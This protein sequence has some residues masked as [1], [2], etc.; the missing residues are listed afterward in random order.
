MIFNLDATNLAS[1]SGSSKFCPLGSLPAFCWFAH[2]CLIR[3]TRA[4]F[5]STNVIKGYSPPVY[6]V[7]IPSNCLIQG[8]IALDDPQKLISVIMHHQLIDL[9]TIT[10]EIFLPKV[11]TSWS[12]SLAIPIDWMDNYRPLTN[13]HPE[14]IVCPPYPLMADEW[15]CVRTEISSMIGCFWLSNQKIENPVKFEWRFTA[16]A[17]P[18]VNFIFRR[19]ST[20]PSF[21]QIFWLLREA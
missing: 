3:W 9:L 7:D 6:G 5:Q 17:G 18:L 13:P 10:I 11:I 1:C 16:P 20:H 8:N 19:I 14:A 15:V 21:L 2:S 4:F 12:S